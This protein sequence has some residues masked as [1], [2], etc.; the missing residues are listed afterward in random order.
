MCREV[1]RLERRRSQPYGQKKGVYL[2]GSEGKSS[3]DIGA[4]L[5]ISECTVDYHIKIAMKN[6]ELGTEWLQQRTQSS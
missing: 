2:L 4:I 1:F 5:G 3:W 6:W